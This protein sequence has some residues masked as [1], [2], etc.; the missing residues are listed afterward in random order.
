MLSVLMSVIFF[1]MLFTRLSITVRDLETK[2]TSQST[3]I[4]LRY[5]EQRIVCR[6]SVESVEEY[7]VEYWYRNKFLN[8]SLDLESKVD[9]FLRHV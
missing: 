3:S 2:Q 4:T 7:V 6:K 9:I 1:L 5:L 8:E